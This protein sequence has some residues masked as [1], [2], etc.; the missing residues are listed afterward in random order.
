MRKEKLKKIPHIIS[1]MVILLHS[2]ERW[3]TGHSTWIFFLLAGLIFISVALFHHPLAARFNKVD[4]LFYLIESVLAFLIS[5]EYFHAGK[6]MLHFVYA[7]A[8]LLQLVAVFVFLRRNK[9]VH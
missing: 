8:G 9:K 3:E 4:V 7:V 1:A 2:Y 6:K 5:Y